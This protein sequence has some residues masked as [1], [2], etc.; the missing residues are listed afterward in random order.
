MFNFYKFN[1]QKIYYDSLPLLIFGGVSL[2]G[3]IFALMLPETFGHKLPDT[4]EEAV[5]I[6]SNQDEEL[7][8]FSSRRNSR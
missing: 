1:Q 6:G 8:N 7:S 5:K 4:V 3:G 2:L